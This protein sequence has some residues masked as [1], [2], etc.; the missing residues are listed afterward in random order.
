MPN[1]LAG[2]LFYARLGNLFTRP[3]WSTLPAPPGFGILTTIGRK[4]GRARRQSVRAIRDGDRVI[5]VCMMG[6]RAAWLKNIRANPQVTIRLGS[7]TFRGTARE[8][9]EPADKQR[10]A[11][12]YLGT[13][14]PSDY[15]DYAV[16]HWGFPTHAK[17]ERAHRKWFAEGIPVS[18]NLER[19]AEHAASR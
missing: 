9:L 18:I 15:V 16:Y 17:I 10:A 5:V 8:V 1:P 12:V 2:S 14:N 19:E 13:T 7:H 3:L 4:T 11:D 6:E